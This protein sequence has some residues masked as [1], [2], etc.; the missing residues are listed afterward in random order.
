MLRLYWPLSLLSILSAAVQAQT[1]PIARP[2]VTGCTSPESHQFDFW[3]GKWEVFAANQPRK[4]VADSLI[5]KLY[6][7]CAVREN[8]APLQ[9]QSGGSFSGYVVADHGWRQTWISPGGFAD[10]KGAWN[11]TA[12][13]IQGVWPQPGHPTQITRMTYTP[14]ADGSVEQSGQTSDDGGRTWQP[15]F[16]FIYRHPS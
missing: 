14:H 13:V 8:W 9:G 12:M 16:D 10:F 7:G 1:A 11:G 5:E 4:K 6:S 15:S 2:P 3:V